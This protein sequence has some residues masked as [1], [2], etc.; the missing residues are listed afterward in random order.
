MKAF[1]DFSCWWILLKIFSLKFWVNIFL[2]LKALLTCLRQKGKNLQVN[3]LLFLWIFY[4]LKV[5]LPTLSRWKG[6]SSSKFN[7]L[8]I[9]IKALTFVLM[10]SHARSLSLLSVNVPAFV[11]TISRVVPNWNKNP[12]SGPAIV[13]VWRGLEGKVRN[14]FCPLF[15][16]SGIKKYCKHVVA[17]GRM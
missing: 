14:E 17:F 13:E 4:T 10:K 12:I 16:L 2:V 15:L 9:M 8:L 7:L 1:I 5:N 11:V 3:L 6:A